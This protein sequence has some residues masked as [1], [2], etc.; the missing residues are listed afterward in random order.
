MLGG[1]IVCTVNEIIMLDKKRIIIYVK[2]LAQFR[3]LLVTC[4][5]ISL[6]NKKNVISLW[7]KVTHFENR[8][9]GALFSM[10]AEQKKTNSRLL[11][12]I[13]DVI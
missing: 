13:R 4:L 5:L 12:S 8:A 9:P 6:G 11:Y 1:K 7:N 3:A 2:N 10:C